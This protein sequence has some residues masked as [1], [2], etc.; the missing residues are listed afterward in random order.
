MEIVTRCAPELSAR[1]LHPGN[2]KQSVPLVLAIFHETTSA[3]ITE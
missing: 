1:A 3:A 2:H